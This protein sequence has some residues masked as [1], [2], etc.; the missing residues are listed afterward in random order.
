MD[1]PEFV[2]RFLPVFPLAVRA[3]RANMPQP[4]EER[5][6][7]TAYG[8][9]HSTR[10][11]EP[12]R[13]ATDAAVARFVEARAHAEERQR[14]GRRLVEALATSFLLAVRAPA[15]IAL[16]RRCAPIVRGTEQPPPAELL[17]QKVLYGWS[18]AYCTS[19]IVNNERRLLMDPSGL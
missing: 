1:A 2:T 4:V 6:P 13:E 5:V 10:V 3:A 12:T 14:E 17:P 15:P 7:P 8:G 11:V 9:T 19:I 18:T 16:L